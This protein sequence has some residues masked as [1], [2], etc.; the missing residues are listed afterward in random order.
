MFYEEK[1]L[2]EL[3]MMNPVPNFDVKNPREY[4]DFNNAPM[5]KDNLSTGQ[6]IVQCFNSKVLLWSAVAIFATLALFENPLLASKGNIVENRLLF[7]AGLVLGIC[8]GVFLQKRNVTNLAPVW[9]R[10]GLSIA[11]LVALFIIFYFLGN[12]SFVLSMCEGVVAGAG[13][14]Y[15]ISAYRSNWASYS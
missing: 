15:A 2:K 12:N 13:V 5:P 14:W 6:R 10:I 7:V 4:P 11:S 8:E 1:C 3:L 9:L